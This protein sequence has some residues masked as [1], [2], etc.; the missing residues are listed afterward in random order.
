MKFHTVDVQGKFWTQRV[1]D[2]DTTHHKTG[3]DGGRLIYSE[4]DGKLYYG[5]QSDWKIVMG[6]HDFMETNT[7]MM[8]GFFPLPDGWN[9]NLVKNDMTVMISYTDDIGQ[10]VGSWTITGIQESGAHDHDGVTGPPDATIYAGKSDVENPR[11]ASN[12]HTHALLSDG[13]HIHGFNIDWRPSYI[14][15]L[16]ARF[17]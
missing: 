13:I 5:G 1:S 10:I 15:F 12:S 14:K 8:F 2:K 3:N 9:I 4:S 17:D 16:E 7:R 11:A 6:K